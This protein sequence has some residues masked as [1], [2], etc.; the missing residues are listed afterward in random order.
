MLDLLKLQS[1]IDTKISKISGGQYK[2]VSIAQELLSS[3]D[4]LI[5]DEPTSGLDSLTCYKT[6]MVLRDL[7]E[8]SKNQM[9]IIV[10]IHQPQ[11]EVFDLFHWVYILATGGRCIYEGKPQHSVQT[12][13]ACNSGH[14]NFDERQYNPASFFIEIA[15]G[16]FGAKPIEA[17]VANQ[18]F[19]FERRTTWHELRNDKHAAELGTQV[20]ARYPA[21]L[22]PAH[23]ATT[24]LS[25]PRLRMRQS[26]MARLKSSLGLSPRPAPLM[27]QAHLRHKQQAQAHTQTS[28]AY[29]NEAFAAAAAAV[30]TVEPD[31]A[32]SQESRHTTNAVIELNLPETP[33]ESPTDNAGV[34]KEA[35]AKLAATAA[36]LSLTTTTTTPTPTPTPTPTTTPL[37]DF[38]LDD[39]LATHKH[40]HNGHFY[41]HCKLLTSRSW[42]VLSK[43]PMLTTLRFVAH[44]FVPLLITVVYG[45]RVGKLNACPLYET[46]LDIVDYAR[47]GAERMQSL[48]DELRSTFEN[49]GLFFLSTYAFTFSTMCLTS[50]SFPLSMHV[51]L[52]EVRNGWYSIP[53]YFIGKT[54][55]DFPLEFVLPTVTLFITYPLTGQPESAYYWRFS[56]AA[57]VFVVTSLIAQTQGLIFGALFMNAMQAAVF[58][59]PV[60][61]T[62][63][64]LL[65][66]FLVRIKK[67][68]MYLQYLS[69]LSYFRYAIE[70]LTIIRYGF[71]QCPCDPA[72][73]DGREPR[74]V[75]VPDQL[76]TMTNY[77][78]ST[79]DTSTDDNQDPSSSY[80]S[81]NQDFFADLTQLLTRANSFGAN[82]TSCDDVKPFP[83][84]DFGLDDSKLWLWIAAL[85][86]TLIVSKLVNYFVVKYSVKLRL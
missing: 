75:G 3:P 10:T 24:N 23:L 80:S 45:S 43:D 9:A 60:S 4:I 15:S 79:Y 83:M 19:E 77:W 37:S 51:L 40:N 85:F 18:A 81:P 56:L 39:R 84:H 16:E 35:T 21:A 54:L 17:L 1:C 73:V 7:A 8:V 20:D 41:R 28:F 50:L 71:G 25:S 12:I 57:V 82:I 86:A 32:L 76:R 52:K 53:T 59:A 34:H 70:S 2:R 42:L 63:L 78:L 58:V 65:S 46:E 29:T 6:V 49:V 36:D 14:L 11:R 26:P 55:A 67:M 5:L 62:P 47:R 61:T 68:P 38:Y 74:A 48:Q 30:A 69:S 66:G 72:L 44:I 31:A 13:S 27:H 22:S 64:I 33:E